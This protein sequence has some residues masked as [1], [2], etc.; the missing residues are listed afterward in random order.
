MSEEEK[1]EGDEEVGANVGDEVLVKSSIGIGK[2]T[3][4]GGSQ[5]WGGGDDKLESFGGKG[6]TWLGEG[7]GV[8]VEEGVAGV[9]QLFY[10]AFLS[11][12][13]ELRRKSGESFRLDRVE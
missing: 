3:S 11:S 7:E 6:G 13:K 4:L 5:I 9:G 10:K 12:K 1:G 2:E 8:L